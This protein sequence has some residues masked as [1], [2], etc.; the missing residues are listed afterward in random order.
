MSQPGSTSPTCPKPT[1]SPN[2]PSCA[3]G[4]NCRADVISNICECPTASCVK[5]GFNIGAGNGD[6]DNE[7]DSKPSLI[8]PI[9]GAIAGLAAIACIAFFVIRKRRQKRRR[10]SVLMLGQDDSIDSFSKRWN[11]SSGSEFA[12]HKDV[13]R[14]AYIPSMIGD[15]PGGRP[16]SSAL[17]APQRQFASLRGDGR[18]KHDSVGSVGSHMSAVLDEAVVMAVT[19]KATPQ[20]MNFK[21]IKAN[22]S[23][24]IQRSNTLHSTNSIKRS[25]SQRRIAD[26]KNTTNTTTAGGHRTPSPL[27]GG[28]GSGR[29]HVLSDSDDNDSDPERSS[30]TS[31]AQTAHMKRQSAVKQNLM[32]S[33]NN[34]FMSPSELL[35]SGSALPSPSGSSV[36]RHNDDTLV[37]RKGSTSPYRTSNPFIS[38]SESATLIPGLGSDTY[39]ASSN[40]FST[41]SSSS[42]PSPALSASSTFASIPIRLGGDIVHDSNDPLSP[43][44]D[45]AGGSNLRPWMSSGTPAL[46]DSTFSTMSDARSS[47]RGDGEEI[48][49]FWGGQ[50]NRDSKASNI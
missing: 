43:F 45:L 17:P 9:I 16:E 20:V 6:D 25:T 29:T 15:S 4:F 31:V 23:D 11:P 41:V 19:T 27:A 12:G 40:R 24:L 39:A 48:M 49:I 14:I 46:R 22:Q 37:S 26:A 42:H 7:S 1:C 13:I 32:D 35:A 38:Q 44:A 30:G 34:P 50:H 3:T 28:G 8:G 2:C 47:T 36:T 5:I 21:T 33:D 18:N 10:S